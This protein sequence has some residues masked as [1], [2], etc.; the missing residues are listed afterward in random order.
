MAGSKTKKECKKK[1]ERISKEE[2]NGRENKKTV[3]RR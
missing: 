2:K 1:R 3:N